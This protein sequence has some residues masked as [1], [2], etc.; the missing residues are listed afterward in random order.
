MTIKNILKKKE[1]NLI[2]VILFLV[3]LISSVN[4]TFLTF[5]NITD[6]LRSYA[7]YGTV[8]LGMLLVIIT[9]GIDV[10][11]GSMAAAI[12]V[13]VGNFMVY[14][15]G[16]VF[17]VV[18][19]SCATGIVF[20]L[21]N[22]F[23]I[24]KLNIPAIVVTLGTLSIFRGVELFITGGSWI[25]AIPQWF[26]DFGKIKIVGIPVQIFFWI[27]AGG[28][29]YFAL[30]YTRFGRG[31]Y[32]YGGNPEAA[33]RIGFSNKKT[34]LLVWTFLGFM[35]GLASFMHLSIIR[36]VDPNAFSSFEL[37]VIAACVLGGANIMGG[38]GSVVGSFLGVILLAVVE[39]G[40]ILTHISPYWHKVIVGAVV[41]TAVTTDVIQIKRREHRM[42]KIDVDEN[43]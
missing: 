11:V 8:A 1:T 42:A 32:A 30:N 43:Y 4:R 20:S 13:V 18:I 35:V 16:N 6:I 29:T 40:L 22:G 3:I 38:E 33:T 14:I 17:I 36:H 5:Q 12:T 28:I 23:L 2:F 27:L 19:V 21:I 9:G 24:A 39:N 10:S 31:V 15:G 34:I 37:T 41:L 26:I 25:T 7:V